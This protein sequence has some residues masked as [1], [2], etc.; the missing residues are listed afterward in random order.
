MSTTNNTDQEE[1]LQKA[2]ARALKAKEK[3]KLKA[4]EKQKST[5]SES[6]FQLKEDQ[7][8]YDVKKWNAVYFLFIFNKKRFL[9]G[10]GTLLLIIVQFVES[11]FMICV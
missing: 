10:N 5:E 1:E 9:F 11:I 6:K 3:A 2:K 7:L 4:L 8:R